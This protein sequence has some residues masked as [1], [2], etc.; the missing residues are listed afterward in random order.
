LHQ[1]EG[2]KEKSPYKTGKKTFINPLVEK[3]NAL[4]M[5][6]DLEKE[7]VEELLASFGFNPEALK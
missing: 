3:P 7:Q 6:K 4:L 1:A 5:P 2:N